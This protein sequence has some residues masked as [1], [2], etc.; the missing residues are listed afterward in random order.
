MLGTIVVLIAGGLYGFS[1]Y[2][3]NGGL[4]QRVE[5]LIATPATYGLRGESVSLISSDGIPLKAWW[6]PA[7]AP[8]PRG[9][10]I[11]LHGMGGTR[12]RWS[13]TP[14]FCT[15]PASRPWLWIC[16]RTGEAAASASEAQSKN[17]EM[18]WPLWIGSVNSRNWLAYP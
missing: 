14:S 1:L 9:V 6:I 5:K 3:L 16:G 10:V 8:R 17:R 2:L 13:A 18:S 7:E 15:T 4:S 11:L 12:L